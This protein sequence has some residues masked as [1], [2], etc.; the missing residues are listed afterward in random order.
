M[1]LSQILFWQHQRAASDVSL[2]YRLEQ[3]GGRYVSHEGR[4]LKLGTGRAAFNAYQGKRIVGSIM[5]LPPQPY[6]PEPQIETLW[7]HPDHRGGTLMLALVRHMLE[8]FDA[9]PMKSHVE[10]PRLARLYR[11]ARARHA[12]QHGPS[13]AL[14]SFS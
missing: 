12:R 6:V 3:E 14:P 11:S 9:F 2:V 7:V 13:S 1:N 10:D 4:E 5:Y 8:S